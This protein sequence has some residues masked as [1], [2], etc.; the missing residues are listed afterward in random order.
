M[1]GEKLATLDRLLV[2]E[3]GGALEE[4]NTCTERRAAI[5]TE[6][7]A[8]VNKHRSK[9]TLVGLNLRRCAISLYIIVNA[10]LLSLYLSPRVINL[11]V[12]GWFY[13]LVKTQEKGF[14]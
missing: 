14:F 6:T 13:V 9:D 2:R 1:N 5:P 4:G 8:K 10:T 3:E 11:I 12:P 7:K